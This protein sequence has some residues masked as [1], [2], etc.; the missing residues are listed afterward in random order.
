MVL[1]LHYTLYNVHGYHRHRSNKHYKK[2]IVR[3]LLDSS[4][5]GDL[6]FVSK[7]KLM[8]LFSWFIMSFLSRLVP[9]FF[10][11]KILAHHLVII[12]V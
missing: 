6:V 9:R 7:D 4:S 3:V 12:L 11:W 1:Y 10:L 8:L 5:D 2:Q